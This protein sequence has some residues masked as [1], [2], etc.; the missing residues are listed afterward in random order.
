MALIIELE[1]TKRRQLA[2]LTA[3]IVQRIG[4]VEGLELVREAEIRLA[5]FD[6]VEAGGNAKRLF[7]HE[8][9]GVAGDRIEAELDLA[10]W[11]G[12]LPGR[13]IVLHGHAKVDLVVEFRRR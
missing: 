10:I 7:E 9:G 12:L 5:Q 4:A 2:D 8:A 6:L 11:I 1:L 13:L 3:H